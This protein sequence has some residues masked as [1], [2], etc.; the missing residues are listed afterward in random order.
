MRVIYQGTLGNTYFWRTY[1]GAEIDLVEERQG[2]LLGIEYKWG[3]KRVQPPKSF[4]DSYPEAT[5]DVVTPQNFLPHVG[6][7][8]GKD[9]VLFAKQKPT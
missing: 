2:R 1:T 5:F 7:S 8:S 6:V 4:L 3:N 9:G